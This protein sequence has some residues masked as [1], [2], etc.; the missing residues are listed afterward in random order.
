MSKS[1]K[2][3]SFREKEKCGTVAPVTRT[4]EKGVQIAF[5]VVPAKRVFRSINRLLSKEKDH[6]SE[7]LYTQ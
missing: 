4:R 2:V 7:E 1:I 6:P 5:L 3:F